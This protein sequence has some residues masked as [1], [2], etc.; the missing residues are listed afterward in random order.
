MVKPGVTNSR[1]LA[2]TRDS[3]TLLSWTK[4]RGEIAFWEIATGKKR[5]SLWEIEGRIESL[6][7]S[8]DDTLDAVAAADATLVDDAFEIRLLAAFRALPARS[9]A[10]LVELM[11]QMAELRTGR[12]RR[13][14]ALP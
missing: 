8:H 13:R 2:I 14:R 12:A 7:L 9:R 10:P 6:A 1:A 11:E 4:E 3:R 5:F